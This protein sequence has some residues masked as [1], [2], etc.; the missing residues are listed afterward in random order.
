M[1]ETLITGVTGFIGSELAKQL[2]VDGHKVYGL[3]REDHFQSNI[4][5]GI[6]PI[7]GD[8]RLPKTLNNAITKS[9]PEIVI[10]TA[11]F[12]PVRFSFDNAITYA[13]INYIGTVNL[14]KAILDSKIKLK[15]LIASS[16]MEVYRE[17][18]SLITE[19]DC[20]GGL[21]PYSISKISADFY[22]QMSMRAYDLPITI[23]RASNT[24]GRPLKSLP[25]EAGGYFVEKAILQM[26]R[27]EKTGKGLIEFDGWRNNKRTWLYAPDHVSGYLTVF[28]ND[29]AI[30]EIFNISQNNC[31]SVGEVAKIISD[32][33]GFDG[34]I[35]WGV[36]PRPYDPMNLCADGNKL[37]GLGWQA[38][39]SLEAGL[40]KTIENLRRSVEK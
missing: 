16:S 25:E 33:L 24:F 5:E 19:A 37:K 32:I 21:T 39:Y 10:H 31:T 11:A 30:G 38:R 27:A 17:K 14:I 26:L 18:N 3:V 34:T 12:T 29:K 2:L 23:L 8:L 20:L 7:K 22:L 35:R 6:V 1:S 4:V 9:Q 13:V 40:K 28:E 15:Q 36:K